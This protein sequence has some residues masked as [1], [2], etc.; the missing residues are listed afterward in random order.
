MKREE[1]HEN[2]WVKS[3]LEVETSC[4]GLLRSVTYQKPSSGLDSI[5]VKHK[6]TR[7][8]H[9]NTFSLKL[10]LHV[11]CFDGLT[12]GHQSECAR[13]SHLAFKT[14]TYSL[15]DGSTTTG[16]EIISLTLVNFHLCTPNIIRMVQY[17][18]RRREQKT[19]TKELT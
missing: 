10:A 7:D 3:G 17:R 1:Q 16:S 19:I 9:K 12:I 2:S 15:P 8:S 6:K 14:Y 13:C 4:E 18:V 5:I 11:Y